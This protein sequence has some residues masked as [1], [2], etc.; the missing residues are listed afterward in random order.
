MTP[1]LLASLTFLALCFNFRKSNI[2]EADT[3]SLIFL[4]FKNTLFT[5]MIVNAAESINPITYTPEGIHLSASRHTPVYISWKSEH[6]FPRILE[7]EPIK[8][9][10]SSALDLHGL[11]LE[12]RWSFILFGY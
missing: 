2:V 9:N 6:F 12:Y 11:F 1:K 7:I 3:D 8:H 4:R 5:Q 10:L